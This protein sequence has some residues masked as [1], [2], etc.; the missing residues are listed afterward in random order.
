[1]P[2]SALWKEARTEQLV[3]IERVRKYYVLD[4]SS[5]TALDDVSLRIH[6]GSFSPS[7]D[8]AS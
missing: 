3:S 4:H 5:V 8:R 6:R 2:Y 1:V 7:Q